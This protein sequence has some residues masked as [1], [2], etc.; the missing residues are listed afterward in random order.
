[1]PI[2]PDRGPAAAARLKQALD[3]LKQQSGGDT[4]AQGATLSEL[5]R[6]A[7]VSRNSVY[8]YHPAILTAVRAQQRGSATDDRSEQATVLSVTPDYASLQ[9]QLSKLAALIDHY[10]AAYREARAMLD[11]R[12]RELAELRRKL[13]CVPAPFRR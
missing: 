3:L 6:L 13:D 12:D 9:D 10:Y 5:C 11:R 2:H 1:M 8:R 4:P 7:G